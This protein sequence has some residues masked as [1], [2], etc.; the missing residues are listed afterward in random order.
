MDGRRALLAAGLIVALAG[1]TQSTAGNAPTRASTV[2]PSTSTPTPTPTSSLSV[3]PPSAPATTPVPPAPTSEDAPAA[4]D[5]CAGSAIRVS[6]GTGGAGLGHVGIPLLFTNTSSRTCHLQ[7]YP[8][9]DGVRADGG[10]ETARRTPRGYLGGLAPGATPP[11]VALAPGQTATALVEGID[12]PVDGATSCPQL[13]RLRVTPP[14]TR[15]TVT[16]DATPPDCA[17]L[18]VHPVLAGTTGTQP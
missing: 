1:C 13:R 14:N 5:A 3:A 10:T 2:S 16:I 6:T 18:L 11:D 15:T 9:V 12:V 8:G 17:G 7:G 4:S